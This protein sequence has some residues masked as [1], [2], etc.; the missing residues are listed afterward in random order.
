MR[1]LTISNTGNGLGI[2][3]HLTHEGHSVQICLQ[4][5][6]L[7]EVETLFSTNTPDV[8]FC[9][10]TNHI[11]PAEWVRVRGIRVLGP[12]KWSNLLYNNTE[13][14][15]QLL[16]ALGVKVT[17]AL[18]GAGDV[19]A[20]VCIWFN[21]NKIISKF[22]V[23][24]YTK[25]MAGDVG[26]DVES[27]G[28][29]A[30]F[31]VDKSKLV[32]EITTPLEKFLR[33]ANHRGC[34]SVNLSISDKGEVLGNSVNANANIPYTNALYENTRK[35]VGD[36]VLAMFDPS[37][38]PVDAIEPYVVGV[39]LSVY[40]YPHAKPTT[41]LEINGLNSA[42]QKHM[43]QMDVL[44]VN[45]KSVCGQL[46]G[47]AGYVTA[48]GKTVQEAQR[49]VYRTISNLNIEGIQYRNDIGKDATE[50]FYKLREHK[51]I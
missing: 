22:L 17:P 51:L 23:F 36:L 32:N 31:G 25:M 7:R 26:T 5:E 15:S 2:V 3:S 20:S 14:N 38:A 42:N 1:F 8:V 4:P 24:N 29:V 6:T 28:Y 34:F 21:G 18:T 50:K 27:S 39:M 47:N 9:D 49:R 19:K 37:S 45:D 10:S 48:R 44:K 33:K 43:W 30:Y 41:P 35:N 12:T 40:P 46:S 11:V 16:T 13:Y